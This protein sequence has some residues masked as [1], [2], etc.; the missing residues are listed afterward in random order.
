MKF[1]IQL[2]NH[3]S[4]W[5]INHWNSWKSEQQQNIW[6]NGKKDL[7]FFHWGCN[8]CSNSRLQSLFQK[9]HQRKSNEENKHKQCKGL[10]ISHYWL[11]K[12]YRRLA[13]LFWS[14]AKF[15]FRFNCGWLF[16][17]TDFIFL[18]SFNQIFSVIFSL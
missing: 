8:H 15:D 14:L 11:M 3:I 12:Y 17:I 5:P 13:K 2:P 4:T 6:R 7:R 1:L 18:I 9:V 10:F 16:W